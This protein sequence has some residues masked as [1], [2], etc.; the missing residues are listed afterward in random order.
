[1]VLFFLAEFRS[2]DQTFW[3]SFCHFGANSKKNCQ[4]F[5]KIRQ[6]LET[7]KLKKKP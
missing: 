3:N 5:G 6:T 2:G 1:M 7:T 4:T